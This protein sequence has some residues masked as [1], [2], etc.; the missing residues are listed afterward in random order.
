MRKRWWVPLAALG[1]LIVLAAGLS[2]V[3]FVGTRYELP[4]ETS[5]PPEIPPSPEAL[6][7][8]PTDPPWWTDLVLI[9]SGTLLLASVIFLILN[10][11]DLKEV[12]RRAAA[13]SLWVV[14]LYF[15]ILR[16]RETT[17]VETSTEPSRE[18]LAPPP[19]P[20]ETLPS[21]EQFQIPPWATFFLVLAALAIIALLAY[22]LVRL[23]RR[24]APEPLSLGEELAAIS[25]RTAEELR[26]GASLHETILR[27]YR[28]MCDLLSERTQIAL[29]RAMTAR[30]FERAL[31]TVGI[32]EAHI[33]RLSRLFE[34]A[35]YSNQKP[36][37]AHEQEAISALEAIAQ[38]YG[39]ASLS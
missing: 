8:S 5:P 6:P 22:L 12:I 21:F 18:S 24:R 38:R 28:E 23:G 15:I 2:Q 20:V 3:S 27:C 4:S 25:Q 17:P 16:L 11:K 34:W 36:S 13:L 26:A 32:H 37:P 7:P 35:R 39:T 33:E 29:G 19:G 14:A 31:A 9:A 10:P 30:E 1:A